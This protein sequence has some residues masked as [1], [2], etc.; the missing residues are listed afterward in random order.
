M[1]FA[2]FLL[3][4]RDLYAT[5]VLLGTLFT[6]VLDQGIYERLDG[7]LWLDT[8]A[9]ARLF[10]PAPLS[11]GENFVSATR[12]PFASTLSSIKYTHTH[13]CVVVSVVGHVVTDN[14]RERSGSGDRRRYTYIEGMRDACIIDEGGEEERCAELVIYGVGIIF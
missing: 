14:P 5:R 2:F 9:R 11:R 3:L 10:L 4:P 13:T 12:S 1:S 8:V 6:C 7:K